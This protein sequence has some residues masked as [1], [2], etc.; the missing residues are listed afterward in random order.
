[1]KMNKLL[2]IKNFEIILSFLSLLKSNNNVLIYLF[3]NLCF[4]LIDFEPLKIVIK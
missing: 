4:Q 2:N 3:F 1:M